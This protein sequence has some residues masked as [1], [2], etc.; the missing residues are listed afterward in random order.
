VRRK[1]QSRDKRHLTAPPRPARRS[2]AG[3]GRALDGALHGYHGASQSVT[4]T[5]AL[6]NSTLTVTKAG[7]GSGTVTSSPAG[8]ACGTTCSAAY[9][10][11]TSVTLTAAP[12]TGSTF[13]GWSGACTGTGNC[14]VAMS[15]VRAVTATF[16]PVALRASIHRRDEE[17]H[18]NGYRGLQPAGINCGTICSASLTSGASVT[19]EAIPDAARPSRLERGLQWSGVLHGEHE[20]GPER[21]ATFACRA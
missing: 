20:P 6:Q 15:T 8:I 19:L 16:A 18:W 3:A 4:A 7:T 12:A 5:F 9:S 13:T 11:S 2:P 21:G 10:Y 14:T 1:L 17:R